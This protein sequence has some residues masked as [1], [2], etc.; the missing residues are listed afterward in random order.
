MIDLCCK[1]M[2]TDEKNKKN[3]IDVTKTPKNL[4]RIELI[5]VKNKIIK[6]FILLQAFYREINADNDNEADNKSMDKDLI[7]ME[8]LKDIYNNI[9][10]LKGI[11]ND[12]DELKDIEELKIKYVKMIKKLKSENEKLA[13]YIDNEIAEYIRNKMKSLKQTSEDDEENVSIKID[14]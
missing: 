12:I 8:E 2:T 4:M 5:I 14:E 3:K 11:Y 7:N 1:K 6:I 9:D 13:K 10:E